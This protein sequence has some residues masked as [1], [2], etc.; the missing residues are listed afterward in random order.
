MPSAQEGLGVGHLNDPRPC[1]TLRAVKQPAL[2][3]NVQEHFLNEIFCLSF[4]AKNSL[5]NISDGMSVPSKKER[6]RLTITSLNTGDECFISDFTWLIENIRHD[7]D[8]A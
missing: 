6:E 5:A 3:V 2:S 7:F 8:A 1:R 4:V